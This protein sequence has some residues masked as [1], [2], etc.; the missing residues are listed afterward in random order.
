M[1]EKARASGSS[2][3]II[4]LKIRLSCEST[5]SRIFLAFTAFFDAISDNLEIKI[6]V[7]LYSLSKPFEIQ[8]SN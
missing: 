4:G 5:Y 7:M 1:G 6:L 2:K 8:T 3:I